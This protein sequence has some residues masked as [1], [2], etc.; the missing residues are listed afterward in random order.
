[1]HLSIVLST[2]VT[3][4]LI[5][6]TS[7][8]Q[9]TWSTETS[10]NTHDKEQFMFL[11]KSKNLGEQIL[12][13]VLAGEL[14]AYDKSGNPMPIE[15]L[16]KL[17]EPSIDTVII[18]DPITYAEKYEITMYSPITDV[19]SFK[20]KQYL[21]FNM[22]TNKLESHIH[23]VDLMRESWDDDGNY[24]GNYFLCTVKF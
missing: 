2:M 12:G 6:E 19:V 15:V 7:Y 10:I 16:H 11:D 24:I 21:A 22:A 5:C 3:L 9:W 20:I 4:S 1:M 17:L 18:V 14:K 8:A 13:K 23:E